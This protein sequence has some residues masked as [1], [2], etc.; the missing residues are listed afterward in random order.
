VFTELLPGNAL[1][2]SV[3]LYNEE[4]YKIYCSSSVTEVGN[5]WMDAYVAAREAKMRNPHSVLI[6]KPIGC[7]FG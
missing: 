1:I 4:L 6:D 5:I 3:T 7:S 2:K